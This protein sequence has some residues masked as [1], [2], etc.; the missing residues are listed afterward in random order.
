[1]YAMIG[2]RPDLGLVVGLV[3]M[4]MSKPGHDHWEAVKWVM[5]YLKGASE[6]CLHFK[7]S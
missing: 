1:M 4:L 6:F 3:N 7:K 5:R 2:S